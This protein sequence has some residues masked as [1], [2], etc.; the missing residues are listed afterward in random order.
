MS[1]TFLRIFALH[2]VKIGKRFSR[3]QPGCHKPNIPTGEGKIANHFLQC[4]VFPV[5]APYFDRSILASSHN[6]CSIPAPA[7]A[8]AGSSV[9]Q[10]SLYLFRSVH[11]IVLQKEHTINRVTMCINTSF[12]ISNSKKEL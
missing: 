7:T 1:K 10:I 4:S 9:Q 6:P 3:P 11:F 5:P 8:Q 12:Q 2:T